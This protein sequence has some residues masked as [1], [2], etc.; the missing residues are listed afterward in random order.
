MRRNVSGGN[1]ENSRRTHGNSS[2]DS[3][4]DP[5]TEQLISAAG[6]KGLSI[7]FRNELGQMER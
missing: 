3:T 7:C 2:I 6:H 5:V 1:Q 4:F